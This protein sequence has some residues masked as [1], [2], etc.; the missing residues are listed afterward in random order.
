MTSSCISGLTGALSGWHCG[1]S[2]QFETKPST[3]LLKQFYC[4]NATLSQELIQILIYPTCTTHLYT[5]IFFSK[6]M[7]FDYFCL[8]SFW[9]FIFKN[10]FFINSASSN[11]G[12]G[13]FFFLYYYSYN[14]EQ[15]LIIGCLHNSTKYIEPAKILRVQFPQKI[16]L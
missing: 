7:C 12:F 15:N 13:E 5:S 9:G 4:F 2:I 3:I 16:P 8:F 14:V 6:R 10:N 11:F 1:L